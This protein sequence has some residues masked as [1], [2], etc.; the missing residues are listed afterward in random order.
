MARTIRYVSRDA[1]R[2]LILLNAK[3]GARAN[4]E[5]VEDLRRRLER[6]GMQV[7]MLTD[8]PALVEATRPPYGSS[9]RAVVAAGGDGTVSAVVNH[10]SPEI[11]ITVLPLG[12]E[13]LL[14]KYL[15]HPFA[16]AELSDAIVHGASVGVDAGLANRRLFLLMA[17]CG[18]DADVVHRLHATRRGHIRHSSYIQ[19]ILASIRRYEY[20]ELKVYCDGS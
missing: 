9:L 2:V 20:P 18:F 8:L 7:E 17:G 6:D 5:R 16:P 1:R 15:E 3:A 14:A 13:N 12:T 4:L 11:P 19:P 10:T